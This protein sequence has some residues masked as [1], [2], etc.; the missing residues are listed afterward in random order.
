MIFPT[1]DDA[2][3]HTTRLILDEASEPGRLPIV[4]W[5][6]VA[7]GSRASGPDPLALL[8]GRG[9]PMVVEQSRGAYERPGLR[10]HRVVSTTGGARDIGG[11]GWTTAFRPAQITTPGTTL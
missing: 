6:G 7:D 5:V 9:S 2:A 1:P 8:T 3:P 11:R 4:R 10:G